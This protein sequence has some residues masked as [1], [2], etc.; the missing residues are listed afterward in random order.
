VIV[1]TGIEEAT[2]RAV[3][4]AYRISAGDDGRLLAEGFTKHVFCGRDRKACKLPEKYHH[5]FRV[6]PGVKPT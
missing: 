1:S 2:S 6:N 3:R 5:I 4:F